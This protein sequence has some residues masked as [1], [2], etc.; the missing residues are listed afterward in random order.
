M[1]HTLATAA[2][3]PSHSGTGKFIHNLDITGI[4]AKANLAKPRISY[5]NLDKEIVGI[6]V[7]GRVVAD[8]LTLCIF[9][10][11][12][13][14]FHLQ[15]QV[16]GDHIGNRNDI[17]IRLQNIVRRSDNKAVSQ[18][19]YHNLHPIADYAG[20]PKACQLLPVFL[21]VGQLLLNLLNR[22]GFSIREKRGKLR[23]AFLTEI[24]VLQL[25]VS[26]KPYLFS[27]HITILFIKESHIE[28]SLPVICTL[29]IF[30]LHRYFKS[31][32]TV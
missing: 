12:F 31:D 22:R 13:R 7:S 21:P 15:I 18:F 19:I 1:H 9:L 3:H 28:T 5:R 32:V 11:Q 29:G 14:I 16:T 27:T 8:L 25:T 2:H 20:R 10:L 6:A 23:R 30:S 17:R 24:S 4:Q 26:K